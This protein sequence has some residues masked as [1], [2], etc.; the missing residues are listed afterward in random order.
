MAP[1]NQKSVI[2]V[3][4]VDDD[5]AMLEISKQIL[6]DMDRSFEI[7][8][9]CSVDEAFKKLATGNYDIVI[10][11]YEMPQKDG[12]QFL[13]ELR[14][15][16]NKIPFILFTGK[17]REQVAIEALNHGATGY[18]N[19]QGS[20]ETVYGELAHGI[21]LGVEHGKSQQELLERELKYQSIF[22]NAEVGMFRTRLDGSEILDF[23]EK[24]LSIFGL[25]REEMLGASPVI[26][27]ANSNKRQEMIH[28]LQ[29]NGYIKDFECNMLNK[30]GE[31]RTCLTS[32]RFYPEEGI[33][34]G[35]IIDITERKRAEEELH[36]AEKLL[37]AVTDGSSD[38]IY[39]KDR[40]SRWLFANP[41]LE[42]IV[43]KSSAEVLGKTDIEIY[44][45]HEIGKA[46]LEN[47]RRIMNS[48]KAETID[49]TADTPQGRRQYISVKAPRFDG[50]GKVIGIIGISHDISERK[51]AE[52]A[53]RISEENFRAYLES[54]PISVF[55]ANISGKYEYV[56]D[57]ACRL[58]GYSQK[59][60]LKMTV[61]QVVPKED[62]PGRRFNQLKEKG[63]FAEEM[64]LKQKNEATIDVFL[65]ASK[66]PDG[67]LVAFCEDISERKKA[68]EV[69]KED[70]HKIEV[71]NE[72]LRVVGSLT[73]HDVGN[74]LMVAKSNLYLLKK[75]IG[76]NPELTKYFDNIDSAFA[77]SD[78]IFEF[79]RLYER[80][81]AEKPS[82]EN[83][84]E[85]FNE[86]VA[87]FANLNAVKFMNECQGLEVTADSLL[88]QLFCNLI[89]NSLKHGQKVSHIRLHFIKDTE[90]LKLFYEDDGVGVSD[91]DKP[92]LFDAGFTT[93]KGSGL[94]LYLVKKMMD[95]YGWTIAE[96]GE[97]GKGAKF[98]ITIPILEKNFKKAD[99]ETK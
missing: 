3:L 40:Q 80:I 89:D 21:K 88:R 65:S 75:R 44:S 94:G 97:L 4:H 59:E 43:G 2:R 71:M 62:I 84:F 16:N 51:K 32:V 49:E 77:A 55:V 93:G 99:Q 36:S 48:G 74:K 63:Y 78:R 19:K 38:A 26:F 15:Q 68:E 66:F 1:S 6:L 57:A 85:R 56:N 95:V 5:P 98:T 92:K 61:Q 42:R 72:K 18:F 37:K 24:Y 41:A 69:L 83:V 87:L 11:D 12:L 50:D 47:D 53:L 79:S 10:S 7:E 76:D 17:G 54:S 22:N 13:K 25:S 23:N 34:E 35:S 90:T 82:K 52:E 27:W 31:V 30:Q 14:E 86:A 45:D 39:V 73:R 8:N 70:S 28:L 9:A 96:E 20:P 33:L 81:G 29:A 64:K 58:L 46:I 91:V 67:K 60:L